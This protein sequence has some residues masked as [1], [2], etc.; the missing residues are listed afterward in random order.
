M[1]KRCLFLTSCGLTDDMKKQF[2]D[3]IGKS[4]R[5]TKI[6]F[7]PTAALE[8]DGAREGIAICLYELSL[9]GIPY[10]NIVIYNLELILSKEY[11][12]TYSS[13]V[14]EPFM[15]ARLITDAE[16]KTFD[17]VFV[18]GGDASV[19]CREMDRTGFNKTL[20]KAI[21]DGL[22]Y[23]GISAGSMYAAG[24]L[25]AGLHIIDNPLI[26]HCNGEK[27]TA[28]TNS[29]DEIRLSD[30]HAVYITEDSISLI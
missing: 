28:L 3:I 11:E 10:D 2:F 17:A 6:L 25:E 5:D 27:I 1:K 30:G 24:N 20:E 15:L 21:N 26:P 13:F 16:M 12:R 4:P 18:G 29:K 7:I 14:K 19:L 22:V 8:T 23:V 9:M